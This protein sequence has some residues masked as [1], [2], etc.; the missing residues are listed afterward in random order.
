M[1]YI[2]RSSDA[3]APQAKPGKGAGSAKGAH[4]AEYL[5]DLASVS[6]RVQLVEREV[7]PEEVGRPISELASGGKG[8]RL[9]RGGKVLGYWEQGCQRLERGD[10]LVE[11]IPTDRGEERGDGHRLSDR[12][13]VN[14]AE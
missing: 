8:L 9:Y 6:G 12:E 7:L 1:S 14:E 10:I 13:K 11:I 4:I 3:D 5:S 2:V